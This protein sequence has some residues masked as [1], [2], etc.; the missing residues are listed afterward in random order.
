MRLW[1]WWKEALKAIPEIA[2]T[3]VEIKH[4][5]A[6]IAQSV[7]PPPPK[8]L[9]GK[10]VQLTGEGTMGLFLQLPPPIVDDVVKR[11]V[12]ITVPNTAPQP[13]DHTDANVYDDL[14]Y[15]PIVG[16]SGEEETLSYTVQDTDNA[17]NVGPMLESSGVAPDVTAPPLP[18]EGTFV[19]RP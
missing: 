2:E 19:N 13:F 5:L 16:A 9:E 1:K 4:I 8:P 15:G 17:G 7:N 11:A 14:F 12:S 3:L 10:F 18:Q 6:D